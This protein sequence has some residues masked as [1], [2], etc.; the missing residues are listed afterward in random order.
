M[1]RGAPGSSG[2]GRALVEM[3]VQ[4]FLRTNPISAE[5]WERM[6]DH[7]VVIH[8]RMSREER[9]ELLPDPE[10]AKVLGSVE[11]PIPAKIYLVSP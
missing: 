6:R 7:V 2:R 9:E 5:E 11:R 1:R 4:S 10:A 3:I 8:D